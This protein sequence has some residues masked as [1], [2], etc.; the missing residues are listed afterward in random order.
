MALTPVPSPDDQ[1]RGDDGVGRAALASSPLAQNWERDGGEGF[2]LK[3]LLLRIHVRQWAGDA[4]G[5][6]QMHIDAI[7]P[8]QQPIQH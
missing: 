1:E 6:H 3:I 2:S 4:I 7:E 5:R 8:L